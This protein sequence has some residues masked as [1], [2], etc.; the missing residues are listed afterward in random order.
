MAVPCQGELALRV[1]RIGGCGGSELRLAPVVGVGDVGGGRR[2][3]HPDQRIGIDQSTPQNRTELGPEP[4]GDDLQE[5]LLLL[6][7][8]MRQD[9]GKRGYADPQ[10]AAIAPPGNSLVEQRGL[11]RRRFGERYLM[12]VN[13]GRGRSTPAM[14]TLGKW[15]PDG[16]H[17]PHRQ[18]RRCQQHVLALALPSA[19]RRPE[20][21]PRQS[22]MS[23]QHSG[24]RDVGR[25]A[26][27]F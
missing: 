25:L 27:R 7:R 19:S 1:V 8:A 4:A 10:A 6:D 12:P 23:C 16:T 26:L 2:R 20:Q 24:K 18:H 22:Q 17:R 9:I 14:Q 5:P 11:R 13:G 21:R 15:E 3:L